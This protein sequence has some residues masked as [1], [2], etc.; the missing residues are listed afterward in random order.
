MTNENN[1]TNELKPE[2]PARKTSSQ[3]V[4]PIPPTGGLLETLNITFTVDT[5]HH[6]EVEMPITPAVKQPFGFLHGGVTIAL[7][8][9]AASRGAELM[10]DFERER[11][12]GIR[13]DIRHKKPGVSG[14]IRGVARLDHEE[15]RTQYWDVKAYDEVGDVISEGVFVT[16]IVTLDRLA[17]KERERA[18]SK[19]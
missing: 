16:K 5:P 2:T 15:R 18:H 1:H 11:P 13:A 4:P 10:T 6:V 17:E 14:V 8:E 7:L 19:D 3:I 12:F 9:T